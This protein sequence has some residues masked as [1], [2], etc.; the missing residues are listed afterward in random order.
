MVISQ[1]NGTSSVQLDASEVYMVDRFKSDNG[2][3]FD[4]KADATQVADHPIGFAKALKLQCDGVSTPTGSHNGGLSTFL[5]GQDIQDFGF[6][7]SGAKPVTVSFYAKTATQN[8]GDTYGLMFGFYG[9]N[10]GRQRQTRSFTVTDAWQ[11][12]EFTLQPNGT[13]QS[14]PI[15]NTNAHGFQIFWS[16]AAGST[17][18]V[19]EETTW[20]NTSSLVGVSG[21]SNFFDQVN[22]QFF[23]TGVQLEIGNKATPF[24]HRSFEHDMMKCMRYCQKIFN[25]QLIG[26]MNTSS[27]MRIMANFTVPMRGTP[28]YTRTSNNLSFQIAASNETSSNTTEA[29]GGATATADGNAYARTWDFGG[30][31]SLADRSFIGGNGAHVFTLDAEL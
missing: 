11:R 29:Q 15:V 24:E 16:L 25:A 18:A 6:G 13:A 5:E 26:T 8:S 22:N 14:D 7:T 27:R 17:D 31:S 30:F 19:A 21:Q 10:N 1:R 12:F 23:L 3:S 28:S 2:S 20:N 4:M 9:E